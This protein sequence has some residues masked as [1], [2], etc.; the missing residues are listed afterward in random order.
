LFVEQWLHSD[1]RSARDDF[2]SMTLAQYSEQTFLV[3]N[4]VM[5]NAGELESA[6]NE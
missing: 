6:S 4:E 5:E 3:E 2:A 1:A